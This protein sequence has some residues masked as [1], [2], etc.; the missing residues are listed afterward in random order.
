MKE[1]TIVQ[2]KHMMMIDTAY[3]IIFT[4]DGKLG[5]V[6]TPFGSIF[7]MTVANKAGDDILQ[8]EV[9]KLIGEPCTLMNLQPDWANVREADGMI[10][11]PFED[12]RIKELPLAYSNFFAE[13]WTRWYPEPV[14]RK[15]EEITELIK[16]YT[17]E[18]QALQAKLNALTS[19]DYSEEKLKS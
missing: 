12:R 6:R 4:V 8:T 16:P 17:D 15:I 3:H 14:R 5:H 1:A 9:Q 7:S 18:L 19:E 10:P 2:Y 11:H 13:D